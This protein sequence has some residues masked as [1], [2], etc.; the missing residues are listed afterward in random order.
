MTLEEFS[1]EFDVMYNN[2]TSN[3]APG[4]SEL[5]K[6]VFLTQAQ[7]VLVKK[8]YEGDLE[9][10]FE[11]TEEMT[12]YLNTLVT[13]IVYNSDNIAE[14]EDSI[15]LDGSLKSNFYN[16]PEDVMFITYESVVL[17]GSD[18]NA[19]VVPTTQ[20][21][22]FNI[23]KNPFRGPSKNRVLRLLIGGKIELISTQIVD[24]YLIR[25]IKYPKPIVLPKSEGLDPY[26]QYSEGLNTELP[27]SLHRNILLQAV[28]LAKATWAS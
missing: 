5:E 22:F 28:A 19:L 18:Q 9:Q 1:F 8:Y 12:E 2:I 3:K 24:K 7:E 21:E 6:S 13:Q 17:D 25:Y 23:H 27:E 11:N 14:M 10:S 15:V 26:D 16:L 4:L 20:D